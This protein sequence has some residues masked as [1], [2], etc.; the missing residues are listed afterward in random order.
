MGLCDSQNDSNAF[1]MRQIGKR[2]SKLE[3]IRLKPALL[4]RFRSALGPSELM[5][6]R[7]LYEEMLTVVRFFTAR[8]IT[9]LAGTP[10]VIVISDE[11]GGYAIYA[12]AMPRESPGKLPMEPERVMKGV[13]RI[14][15]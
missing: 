2:S 9:Q 6:K 12:P 4:P 7:I 10:I 14:E 3:D 11:N 5:R 15:A 1:L 8:L 13:L